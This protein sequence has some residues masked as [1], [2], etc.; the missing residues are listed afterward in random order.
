[1]IAA[2]GAIRWLR[3]DGNRLIIR[4]MALYTVLTL[5]LMLFEGRVR[6]PFMF[7]P[8]YLTAFGVMLH[9]LYE[10]AFAITLQL[11]KA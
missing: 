9:R 2:S 4:G 5:S 11:R 3:P 1:M 6:Y 7:L 10:G 8:W